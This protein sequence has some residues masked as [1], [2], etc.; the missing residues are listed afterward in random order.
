[1]KK[2]VAGQDVGVQMLT[3]ADGSDFTGALVCQVSKD[4]GTYGASAG[5]GPT[6]QADGSFKYLPT[7]AETNAD[8][9]KFKFTA[10]LAI[11]V[12]VQVYTGFPQT[13]DNTTKISL[14]PTTAMRGTDGVDTA[15]M[16]GT[17]GANTTV[18]N[19][20][21][22]SATSVKQ[23]TMETTLNAIPT[24]AMRGTDGV[25]TATM[26]G[27]DSANTVVPDAAGTA[28]TPAEVAT[29]LTDIHLDHLLAVDYDPASPPGTATALLNE[30][31]ES[32]N[33]VTVFTTE[34]LAKAPASGG[35]FVSGE[36]RWD[37]DI[38]ATDPGT[39]DVKVNNATLASI[40][41]I[42]ISEVENNGANASVFLDD[43][44]IG[45]KFQIARSGAGANFVLCDVTGAVVDNDGW[46]TIPVTVDDSGGS[47][48]ANNTMVCTFGFA[49]ATAEAIADAVWEEDQADHVGAGTMG[50]IATE[51]GELQSVLSAGIAARSNNATLESLLGVDD[52]AAADTVIFQVWEEILSGATHN[53]NG[54]SGKR[55]REVSSVIFAEGTAQA[56][57][58]NTIQLASGE[59]TFDNQFQR[60]KVLLVGGTG[61]FQEAIITDSVASTDTLTITPAWIGSNPDS[62]TDYII[63]PAQAHT[64]VRN[65]GYD[66][67][68]VYV[69]TVNGTP[70]TQKGVAGTTT[71]KVDNLVDAYVIAAQ[72]GITSFF[73][74]PGSSVTLPADSSN[75]T[76]IGAS[77][78]V[79]LNSA[80]LDNS[81]ITG[82][83]L[84]GI[85]TADSGNAPAFFLCGMGNV[86]L[87]PS[88]GIE[89]GFFGTLTIGSAGSF[90]FGQSGNVFDLPMI[91]DYGIGLNASAFF[92]QGFIGGNVEIHNTGDGTGTYKFHMNGY[93]HLTVDGTC[94]ATTEV[95]LRGEI[96]RNADVSGVTY[97][98]TA[99]TSATTKQMVFTKTN[100][101]D[102]NMKSINEAE[103]IG[104]GNATPWDGV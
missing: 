42:Y 95:V 16:R 62:S 91:I 43:L 80:N 83:S 17:D 30:L 82:G 39:G 47:F 64:T 19:A 70:G 103:V 6:H 25:D 89:C 76:I 66:G 48:G 27:T 58:N 55:L 53:I 51:T 18:P 101:L 71:N 94:D 33:G 77:Y 29:A 72:E 22:V 84:S 5:T 96:S 20:A 54:S 52:D 85:C 35:G 4:G 68:L 8:H 73:V 2:N 14:I 9:V 40:T 104:D 44:D 3:V 93:G 99:N 63:V 74:V 31:V 97:D 50:A 100:E 1:M 56:G 21:G 15:T 65:G 81:R 28:A 86:T 59:V 38:T 61:E 36:W 46:W 79:A 34:A 32:N 49:S 10:A 23:N 98:E 13:V 67:D 26:R 88:N 57:G 90:T 37:T 78:D 75:R 11:T 69:D 41:A 87:P 92:L 7:Q 24:T 45:D 102:G 12:T 60:A